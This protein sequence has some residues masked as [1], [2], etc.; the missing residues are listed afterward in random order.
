MPSPNEITISQLNRL[1]GLPDQP[2]IVDVCIDEDF[3][4]LPRLI[5]SS[6]RHSFKNIAELAAELTTQKVVIVCQKGKKLSQGAA[7]ILRDCGV[8]A[9]FLQGGILA[10]QQAGLPLIPLKK[11]DLW[12]SKQRPKID[13]IACPWLIR[14]FI[15]PKAKFLFVEKSEIANVAEK[16]DAIAFDIAGERYSHKGSGCTFDSLLEDFSLDTE[17]LRRMATIIRGADTNKPELAP[18]VVG[19]LAISLG[20]SRQYKDDLQQLEAGM[21]IYDALYRWARDAVNEQ[22]NSASSGGDL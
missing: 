21:A 1:I 5:P 20:L 2:I 10:W 8:N 15:N 7:A 12:V 14:R 16:F 3:K 4:L 13:R 17:A 11:S 22:H 19:L 9:E 18:Q 6:F